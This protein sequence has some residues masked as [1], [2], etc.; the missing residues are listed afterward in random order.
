MLSYGYQ[1]ADERGDVIRKAKEAAEIVE[2]TEKDLERTNL[3]A[4]KEFFSC[5]Q[6]AAQ[7]VEQRLI[8]Y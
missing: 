1:Q 7:T 3:E 4:P 2:R 8:R 6:Q 5:L